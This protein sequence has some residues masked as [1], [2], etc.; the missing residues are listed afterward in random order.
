MQQLQWRSDAFPEIFG[1]S[2]LPFGNGRSYGD[3]CLNAG[4]TLIDCRPLNRLIEFDV[5]SGVL[6]C[7]S[8]V[9]LSEILQFAVPKGWFLPVTPGTQL[10]TLGGA[11][12]NDVH[13]KNHFS[14]GTFGRHVLRFELLRSDGSR[15]VCSPTENSG[16][17]NSTIAGLGL[18]GVIC[19]AE[20]QLRTVETAYVDQENIRY[21]ALNDFFELASSSKEDYEHCVAWV[22]CLADGDNLGRGIFTRSNHSKRPGPDGTLNTGTRLSVPFELPFPVINKLS[23][24]AF[25]EL[26][27]RKQGAEPSLAHVSYQSF[28]PLDA[29]KHWNRIYGTRGFF[30]YQCVVPVDGMKDAVRDLLKCIAKSG[31]GSFLAVLKS[32]GALRSPGLLSFP[33]QGATF[34]LDFPNRGDRTLKL[35]AQLDH[36]TRTAGGRIYPAKDARMSADF[37]QTAYPEWANM[38]EFIDPKASSSFWRRVT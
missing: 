34:A 15:L 9:L 1:D 25:N 32:F 20:I 38:N 19:W 21:G 8:G 22:D 12:A 14:A 13:G 30:Q 28:Y 11:I 29:I 31:E 23:L 7:E 35:L 6:R 5:T 36:I 4:Q 17:F 24:G 18:T 33:M 3:V 16:F 10:A 2:Y 27:Y 26:Y 37:F